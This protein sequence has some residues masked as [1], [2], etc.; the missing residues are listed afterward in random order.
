[1]D[2]IEG[3]KLL[4]DFNRYLEKAR[5]SKDPYLYAMEH[6]YQNN[7]LKYHSDWNWLMSVVEKIEA[8]GEDSFVVHSYANVA[9]IKKLSGHPGGVL[10]FRSVGDTKIEAVWKVVLQFV[11]SHNNPNFVREVTVQSSPPQ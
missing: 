5:E 4:A 3:N 9:Q 2:T 8:I 11:N 7:G 10:I 6:A 1:M